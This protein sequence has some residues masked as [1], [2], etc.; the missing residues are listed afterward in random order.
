MRFTL[1]SFV[2]RRVFQSLRELFWT[3]LLT[4]GV[5][6]MTLF[7]FGGFLLI[8]ENVAGFLKGWSQEFKVFA[9]LGED[10]APDSIRTVIRSYPEV[11]DVRYVSKED[12]W[13]AF[14]QSLGSQ[15]GVLEGL[16]PEILPASFEIEIGGSARDRAVVVALAQRL[17]GIPGVQDVEYPETWIEKIRFLMAAIEWA[18]W[19]LGGFLFLVSS[20]IVASTIKLAI[21]ARR[22]EIEIM[23][24]VGATS[25]LIKAPFVL[26]GMLQGFAGACLSLL[27]LG[28]LFSLVSTQL[29]VPLAPVVGVSGLVFLRLQE[30]L[31]LLFLGWLLGTGG[32]LVSVK[33]YLE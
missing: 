1:A 8:Q 13:A 21:M 16:S 4:A 20:M 6:A 31:F 2:M 19:I 25:G 9:Y 24:L 28:V 30:S 7:V 18:K 5:I 27:L 29:L 12:A 14:E 33:R 15:S 22:D 11:E 32:S 17:E 10:A 23:Q 26:E 3:H